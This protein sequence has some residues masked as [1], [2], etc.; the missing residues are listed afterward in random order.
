[1][2]KPFKDYQNHHELADFGAA[3]REL[4]LKKGISQEALADLAGIDRSYMGGVERGQ[5]NVALI[6]IKK[7]ADSL[8]VSISELMNLADL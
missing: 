2:A 5:H 7:I 6:N 3:I 8:E 1:M 4:R